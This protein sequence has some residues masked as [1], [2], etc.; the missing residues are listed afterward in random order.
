MH[1]HPALW[2]P[3]TGPPLTPWRRALVMASRRTPRPGRSA[4]STLLEHHQKR[5]LLVVVA[6]S[7]SF[8]EVHLT[9]GWGVEA[10][11]FA[12][13]EISPETRVFNAF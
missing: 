9:E 8:S 13:G 11:K 7:G 12:F 1:R 6:T 3:P 5:E 2:R 4:S 10:D